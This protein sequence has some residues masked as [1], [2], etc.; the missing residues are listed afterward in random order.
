MARA[1]PCPEHVLH[2]A[3]EGAIE[4]SRVDPVIATDAKAENRT[5]EGQDV[6]ARKGVVHR[7]SI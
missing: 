4:G 5:A 6:A 3:L 1:H 7:W 2:A